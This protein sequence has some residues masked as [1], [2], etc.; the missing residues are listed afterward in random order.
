MLS[1]VV[2]KAKTGPSTEPCETLYESVTLSVRVSV[3]VIPRP[4][5]S[6]IKNSDFVLI[7]VSL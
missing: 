7:V 2:Y 3:I 4:T 5:R 1:G 6:P